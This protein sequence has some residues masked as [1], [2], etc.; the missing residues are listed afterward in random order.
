MF[1]FLFIICHRRLTAWFRSAATR[2][3][4]SSWET[5]STVC[6]T[7]VAAGWRA[8]F[9]PSRMSTSTAVRYWVKLVVVFLQSMPRKT[10]TFLG[11][12][13]DRTKTCLVTLIKSLRSLDRSR[14]RWIVNFQ[15]SRPLSLKDAIET[16]SLIGYKMY[17]RGLRIKSKL[18][19]VTGPIHDRR[20]AM[21]LADH[22]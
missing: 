19:Y 14:S 4:D 11:I 21:Q 12:G 3:S 10:D 9:S 13:L 20:H 15:L 18:F 8:G 1:T 6:P 22:H 17:I 2:T 16:M 5:S 7:P